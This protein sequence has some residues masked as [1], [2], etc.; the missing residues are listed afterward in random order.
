MSCRHCRPSRPEWT[1]LGMLARIVARAWHRWMV[2]DLG[3]SHPESAKSIL[4][5]N[6]LNRRP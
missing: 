1:P 3:A 2:L 5:L 6:E 4:R